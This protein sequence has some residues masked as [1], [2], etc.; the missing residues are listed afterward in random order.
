MPQ[1]LTKKTHKN[2]EKKLGNFIPDGLGN[3]T[4]FQLT[5]PHNIIS[6]RFI[7]KC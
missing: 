2:E 7:C 4:D 1:I 6:C 3:K 5:L